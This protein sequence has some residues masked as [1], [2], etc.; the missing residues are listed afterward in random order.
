LA[1]AVEARDPYTAGHSERV[2]RI[3]IQIAKEMGWSR[4]QLQG[5]EIGALLHDIGKIGVGDAILRKPSRLTEDE[6]RE[7]RQHP[8][9]GARVIESISALR[10]VLPYV[11]Y[12]QEHYDGRG[13]PFGLNGKEIPIEGRLLAVVDSL[14]AM[15]SDR[16]YHKAMTMEGALEEISRHR[17]TQFDPV[18][19]D[20]LMRISS[21]GILSEIF[22]HAPIVPTSDANPPTEKP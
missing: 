17:G 1:N 10:P 3:A 18:V 8:I 15:T 4:E 6:Y 22:S 21:T 9:L 2:T 5:L 14:D 7:M 13:Y 19:V 12:H 16:P 20:A 11:L